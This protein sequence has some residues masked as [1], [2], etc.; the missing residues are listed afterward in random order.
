MLNK[1]PDYVL[2]TISA[3]EWFRE[4]PVEAQDRLRVDPFSVKLRLC[5]QEEKVR[6]VGVYDESILARVQ[7]GVL[8]V[9]E[10]NKPHDTA[11][12]FGGISDRAF[13]DELEIA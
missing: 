9:P 3:T 10:W 12:K 2:Q 4:L 11:Q 8:I 6:I 7:C 1:N 5:E 13:L